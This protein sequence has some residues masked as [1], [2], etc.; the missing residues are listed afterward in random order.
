MI[1]A[2]RAELVKILRRR[3][4]IVTA[5]TAAIFAVGSA[6]IVLASASSTG[7]APSGRGVSVASLSEA[8]GGTEVFTTAVSFAGTF[9]FVVFIGVVAVEFSRGTFRTMLLHQP[10][11][12][13][14]LAGKMAALLGFAAVVL[15][16]T[17][18][19]TW[20]AARLLA[21]SLD[22]ATG[23]WFS[24]DALGHALADFGSVLFWMSGYA[25][26]GMTIAVLVRSV[27]VALAIGIAWAGP[28][29]H[30]LQDAWDPAVRYFPG[31]LLE[32]FVAGGTSEVSASRA[33]VTVV[34]YVVVAACVAGTTFA[35][36]DVTA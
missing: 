12:I 6:A 17:E 15:A 31:L 20:I 4:L 11:R 1:P 33:F 14:L 10:R 27:P 23:A 2:L 13:R 22:V 18:V 35:R 32:A 36:R 7:G 26:L 3:V 19:L 16:A 24:A 8:G 30:L 9:L 21:P 29:E 28:F 34:L 5:V 25:V